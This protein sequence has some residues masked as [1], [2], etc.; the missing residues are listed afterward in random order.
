[1]RR[2]VGEH[3]LCIGSRHGYYAAASGFTSGIKFP[4]SF[5]AWLY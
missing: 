4:P 5:C 3:E 1:M 2:G